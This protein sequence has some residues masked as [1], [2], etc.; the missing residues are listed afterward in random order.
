[1]KNRMNLKSIV[2]AFLAMTS[3]G[4]LL[5]GCMVD[6]STQINVISDKANAPQLLFKDGS[7]TFY[8]P[9]GIQPMKLHVADSSKDP[10]YIEFPKYKTQYKIYLPD[11]QKFINV[12]DPVEISAE[13][14]QQ[15]FA[16]EVV[17]VTDLN[18]D[19]Y[20]LT[21]YTP[22]HKTVL[23]TAEFDY[24]GNTYAYDS[25]KGE[26]LN[27]FQTVWRSQRGTM[28]PIDGGMQAVVDFLVD[29]SAQIL[30]APW[31]YARYSNVHWDIG[32]DGNDYADL[33]SKWKDL[34]TNSPVVD[35]FF[36]NHAGADLNELNSSSGWKS[37]QLRFVYT[38]GCGSANYLGEFLGDGAAV[39]VGHRD[40]SASPFFA[41]P[42]IRGWVYGFNVVAAAGLA[43]TEGG[44]LAR[45]AD[46][47]TIEAMSHSLWQSQEDMIRSSEL[48]IAYSSEMLP[49]KLDITQSAVLKRDTPAKQQMSLQFIG[50]YGKDATSP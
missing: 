9:A 28:I 10:S 5:S 49:E 12:N 15:P 38:E 19:H 3:L 41:F 27:S 23:A 2:S 22:D 4:S 48:G 11:N 8:I 26:F 46:F 42:M 13:Q 43:W 47:T 21:F 1:M 44:I 25:S 17:R 31:I 29:H 36:F 20:G 16:I 35:L 32:G 18:Q 34:T 30:I 24:K 40:T 50:S 7:K 45:A 6:V 37:S 14:T 33:A 39:A